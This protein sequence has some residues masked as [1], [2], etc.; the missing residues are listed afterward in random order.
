MKAIWPFSEQQTAEL[1]ALYERNHG[2]AAGVKEQSHEPL[3][4][5]HVGFAEA[6]KRLEFRRMAFDLMFDF[7]DRAQEEHNMAA[8]EG[9][10]VAIN[11]LGCA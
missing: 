1:T 9:A 8:M 3:L 10:T 6:K 5:P 4:S 7:F 11:M 2:C